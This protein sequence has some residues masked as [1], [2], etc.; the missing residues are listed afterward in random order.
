MKEVINKQGELTGYSS[1]GGEISIHNHIHYTDDWLLTIR[2]IDVFGVVLCKKEKGIEYAKDK[3]YEVLEK[4]IGEIE[5][6]K[7]LLVK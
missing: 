6:L 4:K 2:S 7:K 3:A 5:K 1:E